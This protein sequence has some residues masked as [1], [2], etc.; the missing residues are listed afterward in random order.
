M[1]EIVPAGR[2]MPE[3]EEN[4][5][6]HRRAAEVLELSEREFEVHQLSVAEQQDVLAEIDAILPALAQISRGLA[7]LSKPASKYD[8]GKAVAEVHA[9]FINARI[10]NA[11][12]A[13]LLKHV[14]STQ[15]SLG[16]V[17]QAARFLIRTAEFAPV[18]AT[19]L[20][21]MD[22]AEMQMRRAQRAIAEMP[23]RREKLAARVT[24]GIAEQERAAARASK[25]TGS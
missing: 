13:V 3:P 15:P 10:T 2:Q 5:R 7:A 16:A 4:E 11:H 18:T 19:F 8:I 23:G 20:A 9:N 22:D 25:T 12:T 1:N 14:G 24:N 6:A 21:A 17:Q